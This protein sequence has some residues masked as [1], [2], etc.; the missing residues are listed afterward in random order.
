MSPDEP[1]RV[2]ITVARDVL[3]RNRPP[4]PR[5]AIVLEASPI[6]DL[7]KVPVAT[8][9]LEAAGLRAEA[10]S[11]ERL[12][13]VVEIVAQDFGDLAELTGREVVP[14]GE[15]LE[16][17][18]SA[19]ERPAALPPGLTPADERRLVGSFMTERMRRWLDEPDPQLDGSTPRAAVAGDDRA[20]VIRLVRRIENGVER[21]RRRGE[22][23][24]EV[25]WIR[26]ELGL[27]AE[28]AA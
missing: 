8:V 7:D 9:R 10:I 6:D 20:E 17:R 19:S 15:A 28:L 12:E 4:L 26:G 16:E 22:P 2:D 18:R 25:A 5:G 13:H 11:E 27:E 1:L 14:V 3:V 23:F 21:A 24:A